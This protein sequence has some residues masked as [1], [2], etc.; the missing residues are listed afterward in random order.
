[1]HNDGI[2]GLSGR[3]VEWKR[4]KPRSKKPERNE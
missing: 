2:K 3:N 1:L 4:V